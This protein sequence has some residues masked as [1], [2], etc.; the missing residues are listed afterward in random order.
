MAEMDKERMKS[1][2]SMICKVANDFR[3]DPALIAAI[4]SRESRA[5]NAL[6]DGWGD[7][8]PKWSKYN[9]LGLMQVKNTSSNHS[10]VQVLDIDCSKFSLYFCRLTGIQKEADTF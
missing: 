10:L 1:Y 5:G 7:W 4:I 2:K 3:I 6:K 9:A 8:N